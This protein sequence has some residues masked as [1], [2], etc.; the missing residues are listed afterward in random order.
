MKLLVVE[1]DPRTASLLRKGLSEAGFIVD[2]APDGLD[3][4]ELASSGVHDLVILDVM[5][6]QLNGWQVLANLRQHDKRL[7]VLMLTSQESVE[8]RVRGLSLG[9]DDY[10]VKPFSF[11]E[12]LARVRSIFR[13]TS[14]TPANVLA[15]EDLSVD[16]RRFKAHRG[17]TCVDIS[18]KEFQ[19]LELLLR[20][21]GEVL[22]RTFISERVWDM[23][24]D[25]D[26]NVVEVNIGRL[27]AKID[28]PFD[29][30]LIHTVRGRG[31]VLR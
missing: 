12:L 17:E 19:L 1:D 25:S 11:E 29:R 22:S 8:H 10:L 14:V 2:V 4:L 24:Y 15:Y 18:V 20:H 16:V 26:S 21:Q 31:Y 3:G 30:K 7:P 9:A 6:P 5:L 27:R 13:R 28:D 23:N